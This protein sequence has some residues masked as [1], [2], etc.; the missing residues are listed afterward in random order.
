MLKGAYSCRRG[1]ALGM[2]RTMPFFHCMKA[3]LP[4]AAAS[5]GASSQAMAWPY[6]TLGCTGLLWV[7]SRM[8]LCRFGLL[9][10]LPSFSHAYMDKRTDVS[11]AL[12]C[13][14]SCWSSLCAFPLLL[15]SERSLEASTKKGSSRRLVHPN[16]LMITLAFFS[17]LSTLPFPPLLGVHPPS[18]SAAVRLRR[19][20]LL[21]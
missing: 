2:R 21:A 18:F 20:A 5:A 8:D 16:K 7:G 10:H 3:Q 6:H 13:L 1:S 9:L 17:L 19:V 12:S 15:A 11:S 14:A 4:R